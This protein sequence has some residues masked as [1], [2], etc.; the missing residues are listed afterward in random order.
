MQIANEIYQEIRTR[1]NKQ[2][3]A[4]DEEY[5]ELVDQVID[6]YVDNGKM[7]MD[8]DDELLREELEAMWNQKKED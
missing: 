2:G 4:T 7:D 3:L 8:D 1:M 5:F 6:E